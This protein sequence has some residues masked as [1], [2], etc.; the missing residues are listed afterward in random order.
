MDIF[1]DIFFFGALKLD[2]EWIEN[3]RGRRGTTLLGHCIAEENDTKSLVRMDG[4]R[5]GRDPKVY[6]WER[7]G[8]V[9]H[10]M[11]H[12]YIAQYSCYACQAMAY[13][14]TKDGHGRA[15][16]LMTAKL[17]KAMRRMFGV[18]DTP[19]VLGRWDSYWY[20]WKN[21]RF[22]PSI[23]DLEQWQLNQDQWS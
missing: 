11:L 23:H 21:Q 8:T 16:H 22:L 6:H 15:W 9:L 3:L 14:Q 17:E 1:N 20:H 10:E 2:F 13:K 5:K 18:N 7:L 4:M 12:A 19:D